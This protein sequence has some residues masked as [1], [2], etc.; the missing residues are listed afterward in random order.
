MAAAAPPVPSIGQSPPKG[1]TS[2][3]MA[4]PSTDG[5]AMGGAMGDVGDW[6][7]EAAQHAKAGRTAQAQELYDRALQVN[8]H[9]PQALHDSGLLAQMRGDSASAIESM[10]R[11]VATCPESAE[12]RNS[13]AVVLGSVGRCD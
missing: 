3:T 5:K 7:R 10:S 11:A 4:Q 6:L 9:H 12:L 13:L 2:G 8:P 1:Y